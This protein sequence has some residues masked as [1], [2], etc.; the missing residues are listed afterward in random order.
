MYYYETSVFYLSIAHI[1]PKYFFFK[2][3][4]LVFN[5]PIKCLGGWGG[6]RNFL[7]EIL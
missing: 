2:W 3:K 7:S 4:T 6:K 1:L 5:L